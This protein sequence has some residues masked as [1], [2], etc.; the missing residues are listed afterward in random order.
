MKY[1]QSDAI[2]AL[3]SAPG[4]SA[5]A[6]IRTSGDQSLAI[7]SRLFRGRIKPDKAQG[8]TLHHGILFNPDTGENID[9]V[10][11]G[12][13]RSPSSYTGEESAEISCH[14]SMTII[15]KIMILLEKN[16]F[17][18]AQPGEFTLR[19]FLNR[20]I[21]LTRAEAVNEI[22]RA[23]SDKGRAL[24]LNRLS[25][26]IEERINAIKQELLKIQ[27]GI[28]VRIDYP[29]EDLEDSPVH[30]NQLESIKNRIGSL[31]TTYRTGKL[32]QEGITIVIAGS[33]NAGKSTLF[34]L[35]LREDRA[36]VSDIHGTTRDYIEGAITIQGIPV[37]LFDTAGLRKTG[38]PVEQEGIKRTDIMM[39][40]AD[41][42][43]YIIDG[44][45]GIKED[46]SDIIDSLQKRENTIVVWN[47]NDISAREVPQGYIPVS[48]KQGTGLDELNREI[49][50]R[51]LGT[52]PADTEGPVIDS[53][54][55][56]ELL[57]H[58][59]SAIEEFGQGLVQEVPLDVLATCLQ[60]ALDDLGRITG[61][62]T[63]AD[64]LDVMFSQFCVGK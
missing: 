61:E 60:D 52:S 33:T 50:N 16:G 27:A 39:E 63:Q 62:V 10:I 21:D 20:K 4:Q 1:S 32:I 54:R 30:Q 49:I 25:G 37:R 26:V 22:I 5:I 56:K 2:A 47:K 40:H 64:M 8:H 18:Q 53:E 14:G 51:V 57:T 45:T 13:Y 34:N 12:I 44:S 3:A 29:D 46:E 6:I 9:E 28:E 17:R 42:L 43:L 48:A 19:A 23:R 36:I 24:A 35:L 55:Q 58:C 41:V 7:L 31:L 15:K 11:L 59:L 38:H